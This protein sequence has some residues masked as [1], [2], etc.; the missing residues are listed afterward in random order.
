MTDH[1]I[2]RQLLECLEYQ[3]SSV[4]SVVDGLDEEAWHKSAV[5]SGWTIAGMV[6]H[7]GNA[8]RHWFQEVVAGLDTDFPWD[9]DRPPYDPWM[10]FT[11]ARPSSE[12]L[13]YY[14][15]QCDRADEILAGVDLS[16]MPRGL[17]EAGSEIPS[18][19]EV[20][21]HVIEETAAHSGHLEIVRELLD[22]E[23]RRGL[24]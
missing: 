3:R 17:H 7:L 12:V 1:D 15:E 13:A 22:G 8:E 20:I 21:L 2:R 5:P 6:E 23:T 19:H 9:E 16:D 10:T 18:V 11:C 14:R 4:R 24:R